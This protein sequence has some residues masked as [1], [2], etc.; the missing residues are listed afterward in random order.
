MRT[1]VLGTASAALAPGLA[2]AGEEVVY[3]V[4][5]Q[6]YAGYYAAAQGD[7]QGLVLIIHDWDGLG[8]YE[9]RRADMLAE[10]GYAAFAVDL[11]GQG[12]PPETV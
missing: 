9:E 7:P 2:L 1:L 6:P 4:D 5:G 8:D 3:D 10:M 11:F 12:Y